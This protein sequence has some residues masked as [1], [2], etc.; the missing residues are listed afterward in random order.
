MISFVLN[1]H[2]YATVT[3]LPNSKTIQYARVIGQPLLI[4]PQ[5]TIYYWYS[6]TM[7]EQTGVGK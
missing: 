3:P 2:Y 5:M 4:Y 7:C 1:Y 6:R